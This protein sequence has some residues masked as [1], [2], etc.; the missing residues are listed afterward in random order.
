MKSILTPVIALSALA[1]LLSTTSAA[2]WPTWRGPNYDG[3]LE[4]A[5]IPQESAENQ[6]VST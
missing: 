6:E 5:V 2:D 4:M 3:S 1:A